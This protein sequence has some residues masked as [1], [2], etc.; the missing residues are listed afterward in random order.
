MC[1][2]CW[3]KYLDQI[4]HAG[5]HILVAVPRLL[6]SE[7]DKGEPDETRFAWAWFAGVAPDGVL[8]VVDE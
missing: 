7:R 2:G 1:Q 4:V 3:A 8:V 5:R 6:P